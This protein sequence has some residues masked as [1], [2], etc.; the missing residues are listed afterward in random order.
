MRRTVPPYSQTSGNERSLKHK[1]EKIV[2]PE[3]N[4]PPIVGVFCFAA[5][6]S[7]NF[8]ESLAMRSLNRDFNQR[9]NSGPQTSDKISESIPVQT[10]TTASEVTNRWPMSTVFSVV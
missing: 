8:A 5:C 1:T 7:F 4:S 6:S 9:I 3:I 2:V 10:E